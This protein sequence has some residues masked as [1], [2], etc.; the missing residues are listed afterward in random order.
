MLAGLTAE[1]A[2]LRERLTKA[3]GALDNI[4]ALECLEA[5]RYQP[6]ASADIARRVNGDLGSTEAVLRELEGA[7]LI[8]V[9]SKGS[10]QMSAF[11]GEL[12]QALFPVLRPKRRDERGRS[13]AR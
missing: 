9:F 4:P 6:M 10:W 3:L 7:G 2:A 5:L 1:E 8:T 13:L 11:G 12:Y